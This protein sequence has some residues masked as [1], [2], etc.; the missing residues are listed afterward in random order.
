[1][2]RLEDGWT[3]LSAGRVCGAWLAAWLAVGCG[4][5]AVQ[6]DPSEVEPAGA[7]S[8]GPTPERVETAEPAALPRSEP[9]PSEVATLLDEAS[10][11]QHARR[12][13][14]EHRAPIRYR[15]DGAVRPAEE[16]D[17]VTPRWPNV[18]VDVVDGDVRLVHAT[19]GM[20]VL[21]WTRAEDLT[22]VPVEVVAVRH[23]PSAA[24]PADGTPGVRLYPGFRLTGA[25]ARGDLT[26]FA[27]AT[28]PVAFR[29]FVPN[30]SLGPV[31]VS[32]APRER[33]GG[34]S[35]LR[36]NAALRDRPSGRVVAQ[37]SPQGEHV[38]FEHPVTLLGE[39]RSGQQLVSY[40]GAA[41]PDEHFEV[42][43]W[44]STRDLRIEP[45]PGFGR[46]F[47]SSNGF[48]SGRS[49]RVALPAGTPIFDEAGGSV[50]GVVFDESIVPADQAPEGGFAFDIY[51]PWGILSLYSEQGTVLPSEAAAPSP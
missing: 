31:F 33:E 18:V 10:M 35:L 17:P 41:G 50:I 25:M 39:P 49:L 16:G 24:A 21:V 51:S 22:H 3:R 9:L 27:Y 32:A 28:P 1:M 44:A 20:R 34:T 46:G 23:T 14:V 12:A 7:P 5:T 38:V 4:S 26:E 43:G 13:W 8:Q 19:Q 6:Q 11:A 15:R 29:G 42:L 40:R 2:T 45:G 30:A 47:G 48:G 36:S 37:F